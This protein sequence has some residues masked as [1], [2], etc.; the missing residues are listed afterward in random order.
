[1]PATTE[2]SIRGGRP[3]QA[4]ALRRVA[5]V[6]G[7]WA[8]LAAAVRA[9][10]DG[11]H[12][13]VF[14]ASRTW[15]GRA[16]TVTLRHPTE[17]TL[18]NGQHILIGAYT[19]TLRLMQ[20]VGVDTEA[21]FVRRPLRMTYPDGTGLALP[22]WPAPLD[23][24]AGV[25]GTRG[26]RWTDKLALLATAARWQ[27]TGFTCLPHTTVAGLCARLP[28]R[29]QQEF[30]A[31]LCISALNTPAD[32]ASGQVFLR[33][34][35]DAMFGVA[36]GSNLLLPR[37]PLGALW[38][39]AAVSWLQKRPQPADLRLG[40][41]VTSLQ[42]ATVEMPGQRSPSGNGLPSITPHPSAAHS[43]SPQWA[44]NGEVF[45]HVVLANSASKQTSELIQ[46]AL[47]AS[48]ESG[49][50]QNSLTNTDAM[51]FEA[52]ATVYAWAGQRSE[53]STQTSTDTHSRHLDRIEQMLGVT[54]TL[55]HPMLALRHSA[56]HPAQF[57]FDRGQLG[58]PAGL[59]AFVISA[60]GT[61]TGPIADAVQQQALTQLGLR[62]QVIQTIVEKRATFAC[63]PGLVRPPM[64]LAPGLTAAGDHIQGPYPATL[65]GAMRSGWSA[66]EVKSTT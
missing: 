44:V 21:V 34:L 51:A 27:A 53:A 3:A 38:P 59:L 25:L 13:T 57:V 60:S 29:L 35:K 47:A 65:E 42:P 17:L 18:D 50:N 12:V 56:R 16:R 32:R 6:G 14:E 54:H 37:V 66:G 40:V 61:E 11:H 33:V 49:G 55:P 58:G 28:Q 20:L 64:Q 8:G 22:D 62:I 39:D 45:D 5:V 41:R 23:V 10:H 46:K 1:M 30:I 4:K 7:G 63:T 2:P 31:P 26:W 52:I 15:G 9:A 19:E 36:K 24:L 43:V 48:H